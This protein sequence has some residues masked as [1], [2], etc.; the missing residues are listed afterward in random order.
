[1]RRLALLAFV[2][3]LGC[4]ESP[5][6]P[7]ASGQGPFPT[8]AAPDTLHSVVVDTEPPDN[9]DTLPPDALF[10]GNLC[11]ALERADTSGLGT[12]GVPELASTDSCVFQVGSG[13]VVVQLATPDQFAKPG[14][15]GQEI[16]PVDGVGLGAIGVDLTD[17]YQVFVH[18]ENG[19]FSVTA[20]DRRI[21][22][23]LAKAAAGRSLP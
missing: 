22:E 13:T 5:N 16:A 11:G 1:M 4:T 9:T 21:A 14:V 15:E 18:V 20:A 7:S 6:A 19:Y 17:R 3:L 10:G 8:P 12:F 2:A 23:R